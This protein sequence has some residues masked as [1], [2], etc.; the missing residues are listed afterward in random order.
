[1]QIQEG[2][3]DK[4]ENVA[5]IIYALKNALLKTVVQTAFDI[6]FIFSSSYAILPGILDF[7]VVENGYGSAQIRG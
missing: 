2:L 7:V 4:L 5:I 3:Y 1:L 6:I